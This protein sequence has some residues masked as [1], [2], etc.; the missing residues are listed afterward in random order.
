M[1]SNSNSSTSGSILGLTVL[2]GY[3]AVFDRSW[4]GNG[5]ISFARTLDFPGTLELLPNGPL[6]AGDQPLNLQ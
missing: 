1:I 2:S 4:G 3:Y 6:N 5:T